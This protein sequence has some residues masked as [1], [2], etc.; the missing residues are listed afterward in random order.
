VHRRVVRGAT[1][2]PQP[3]APL[4]PDLAADSPFGFFAVCTLTWC[5]CPGE[6]SPPPR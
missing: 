4:L 5:P 6:R 1:R 3:R 2:V